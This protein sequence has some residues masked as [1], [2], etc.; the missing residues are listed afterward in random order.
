MEG[1]QLPKATMN[2]FLKSR[3]NNSFNAEY[4]AKVLLV[5]KGTSSPIQNSSPGFP[6]E[7]TSC[8]RAIPKK[9]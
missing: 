4:L 2:S 9:Q 8:A 1:E 5:S 3:T 7:P 6:T